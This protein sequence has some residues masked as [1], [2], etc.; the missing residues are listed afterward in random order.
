MAHHPLM[1]FII[2]SRLFPFVSGTKNST[3]KAP[4]NETPA[5][6]NIQPSIPS[7]TDINGNVLMIT[8]ANIHRTN[9]HKEVPLE[10]ICDK[11]K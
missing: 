3:N 4:A 5:N 7:C 1:S 2:S 6:I 10:R 9:M 8:K 11:K